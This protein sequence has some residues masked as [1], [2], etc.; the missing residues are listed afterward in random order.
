[1]AER[2]AKYN[3]AA[4]R[5]W[6]KKNPEHRKYLS[7]RSRARS[8]IRDVATAEDLDELAAM[9][10]ERRAKLEKTTAQDAAS[11]EE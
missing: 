1:M 8:F 7:H 9:I 3:P 4:D 11:V 2:K 5:R 10:A 6:S